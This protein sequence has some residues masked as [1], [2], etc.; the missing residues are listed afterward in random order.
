[1][2]KILAILLSVLSLLSICSIGM[3][4][5]TYPEITINMLH[6]WNG[7]GGGLPDDQINNPVAQI[8][9]EN[10][11]IHL[12]ITSLVTSELEALNLMFASGE[13][14]D[15]VNAPFW[16]NTSGEG[17]VITNAALEGLLKDVAPA[18]ETGNYPNVQKLFDVGVAADFKAYCVDNPDFNGAR[19]IIPQQTPTGTLES[20][21]NWAYG[22][23]CRSDILEALGVDPATITSAEAVYDL[24][25]KISEGGFTDT[26]GNAV[27]PCGTLHNGCS[28]DNYYGSFGDGYYLT[29]YR[30]QEDGTITHIYLTDYYEDV[31]LFMRKMVS[32]GLFDVECVNQT[33][34]TAEE[35]LSTGKVAMFAYQP[36]TTFLVNN[37]Y[38]TNPEMEYVVLG[39]QVMK[40]GEV[41]AQVEQVGRSGF[42][43]MFMP[44]SLSEEKTD[45]VLRVLDFLNSTEGW[46]AAYYGVAGDTYTL[47]EAGIP[48]YTDSYYERVNADPDFARNYGLSFYNNLIGADDHSVI[49]KDPDKKL[50]KIEEL[51]EKYKAQRKV[52]QIDGIKVEYLLNDWEGYSTYKDM[53]S[54]LDFDTELE[55]AFFAASD[56]EALALLEGARKQYKDAGLDDLLTWLTDAYNNSEIKDQIVF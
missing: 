12:N 42:P 40:N 3:A 8:I 53:I 22:V 55:R 37:L 1:M 47:N 31:V 30:L 49:W 28:Y 41:V 23:Y 38:N 35:K 4:E 7:G 56:E 52:V 17:L 32:D 18:L 5:S 15:L 26:A 46:L 14:P 29:Q 54:T 43:C 33:S 2:K 34:T 9:Y 24:A 19:Y 6:C 51:D 13:I 11:G 20:V 45:A 39:P 27:I 21:T 50:S 48:V 16:S 10:T 25:K 44:A 36:Y